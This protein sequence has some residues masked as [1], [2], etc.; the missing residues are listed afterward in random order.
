MHWV[1]TIGVTFDALRL[2]KRLWVVLRFHNTRDKY[3]TV[4]FRK[5]TTEEEC[6]E[7]WDGWV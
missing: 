7:E 3:G 2:R 6:E 4:G 5:R 1:G